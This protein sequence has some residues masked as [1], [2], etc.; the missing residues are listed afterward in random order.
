MDFLKHIQ[1]NPKMG[2]QPLSLMDVDVLP[3]QTQIY[4]PKCLFI[5][6]AR[7]YA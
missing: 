3:D 1:K 4:F 6:Y 7:A 5:K 2:H